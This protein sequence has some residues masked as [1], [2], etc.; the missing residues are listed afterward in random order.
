MKLQKLNSEK[1]VDLYKSGKSLK[2]ISDI[3]GLSI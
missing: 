3:Y 1:V 2:Q